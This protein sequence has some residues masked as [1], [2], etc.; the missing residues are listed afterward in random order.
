VFRPEPWAE[1]F[2]KA[3]GSSSAAEESLEYLRVF[4][5]AALALPGD[6][7]GKNDADRLGR[8]IKAALTKSDSSTG[9][10]AE[11]AGRVVQ[12]MVRKNCFHQY[13]KIIREIEKN[14]NKQKG[15]EEVIVEAAEEPGEELVVKLREKIKYLTGARGIKLTL[16]LIPGIIGGLRIRWGSILLDG[17]VKRRMQKMAGDIE[18]LNVY[19]RMEV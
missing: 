3:A 8:Y 15:I 4:C 13:K 18:A 1:A 6:L 5:R 19:S 16:R 2:I 12:I 14:I 10:P 9:Y 17:S 7:S 11:L